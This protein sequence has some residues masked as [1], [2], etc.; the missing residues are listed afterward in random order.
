MTATNK[1]SGFAT[2]TITLVLVSMLVAVSVF[3]GK[4]LI[5]DK[6][7]TLNEIEYRIAQ[8]AAEK[9]I[10]EAMAQ[11]K[12]DPLATSLSGTLS[13]SAAT[14]SYT[15]TMEQGVPIPDAWQLT[16][17]A[18]LPNGSEATVSVQVAKR[19]VLNPDNAGPAAPLL[20]GGSLP[21]SGNITIVANPNGG[22]P[23]V[24]VSVWTKSIATIEGNAKTC[25]LQAYRDGC[26]SN[27]AYS[28]KDRKGQDIVD[29]DPDFPD[30]LVEYLFGV[31]DNAQS[32]DYIESSA[33]IV[34][35]CSDPSLKT[36]GD[37]FI[38]EGMNKSNCDLSGVFGNKTS[39]VV[40]IVKDGGLSINGSSEVYGL[41]FAYDSDGASGPDHTIKINGG[42]KFYGAMVSN[43]DKIDLPNGNYDS[44]YD[45]DVISRLIG[46]ENGNPFVNINIIP[47]SWKDW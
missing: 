18:I 38:I 9:G 11:L 35:S 13:T 16:S 45:P 29:H 6:R 39:P 34:S 20:I 46:K 7:I 32:W 3:I 28:N 25:S 4:V 44:V 26:D 5:S 42:A 19:S 14:A 2:L 17:V 8:A 37:F 43:H 15:V 12:V 36:G 21:A 41:L 1:E 30:D 47:G 10:A 24:P 33:S 31:P 23:G 27:N 22:G 40:I